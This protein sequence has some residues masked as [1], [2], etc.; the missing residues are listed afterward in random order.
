MFRLRGPG[1]LIGAPGAEGEPA[2]CRAMTQAIVLSKAVAAFEVELAGDPELA[3]ATLSQAAASSIRLAEETAMLK[4]RSGTRRLA[5]FLLRLWEERDPA[6][7]SARLPLSKTDL[8]QYLGMTPQSLSR[9]LRQLAELGVMIKG[10]DVRIQHPTR[11]RA[12]ADPR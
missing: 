12:F 6:R 1:E 7:P 11:V 4:F 3:R 9:S 5:D 10:R 8:A 2:H